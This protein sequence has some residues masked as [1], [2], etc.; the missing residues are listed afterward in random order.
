MKITKLII[1]NIRNHKISEFNFAPEI[2]IFQGLNGAGKTS[3]LEAISIAGLSKSFMQIPDSIILNNNSEDYSI[4]LSATND[5]NIPYFAN[6]KYVRNGKKNICNSIGDNILPKDLIGELPIVVLSPDLK[7]IT[8]GSPIDRRAL[9]DRILS[10]SYKSYLNNWLKLKRILRQRSTIL[11]HYAKS[12]IIDLNQFDILTELL[13]KISAEIIY[14]RSEFISIFA[15]HFLQLYNEVSDGKEVV[16]LKYKPSEIKDL[17]SIESITNELSSIAQQHREDE[18]RRGMNLFGPQKDDLKIKI[19]GGIAH[20]YA[21]QG[22]HKSLLV[23]IKFAEFRFIKEI[24]NETPIILLDD[25][26]SELDQDRIEKVLDLVKHHKA[27]TFISVNYTNFLKNL[28]SINHNDNGTNNIN[29]SLNYKIF[30]IIDGA[31]AK[32]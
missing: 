4:S 8:N 12:N 1:S 21:S 3:I 5:L 26:F 23:A 7:E 15:K 13:I 11:L 31:V 16:E 9:I 30:E 10:Q 28:S 29:D 32:L 19:N 6:I 18:L 2:N 27:Q 20:K 24:R 17:S 22:Q 14:K 25:I